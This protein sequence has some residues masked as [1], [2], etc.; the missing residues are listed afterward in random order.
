[1]IALGATILADMARVR[2]FLFWIFVVSGNSLYQHSVFPK[3][4]AQL[5]THL[6]T[7]IKV[8]IV[9]KVLALLVLRRLYELDGR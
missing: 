7:G 2:R 5:E 4:Q 8:K 1:M 6:A 3:K 9:Y